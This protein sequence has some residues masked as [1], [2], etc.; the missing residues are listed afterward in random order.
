MSNFVYPAY[1]E[2]FHKPGS[3][4]FD[5]LKKVKKPFQILT[6]G[7]QIIFKGGKWSAGLRL[8]NRRRSA[9]RRKIAAVTGANCAR[10]DTS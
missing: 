4:K 2:D 3:V 8:R 6:G 1:F 7:Y 9:S 10:R 5:H